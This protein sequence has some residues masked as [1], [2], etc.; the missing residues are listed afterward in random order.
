MAD[1][2]LRA[3]LSRPPGPRPRSGYSFW[4]R[5]WASLTG[6]TLPRR[7]MQEASAPLQA[8][9]RHAREHKVISTPSSTVKPVFRRSSSVSWRIAF[10][11]GAVGAG[12]AV[13]VGGVTA[14]N[15]SGGGGNAAPGITASYSASAITSEPAT[16][17][18]PA[19]SAP[20]TGLPVATGIV[21]APLQDYVEIHAK[22]SLSSSVVGE[23]FDGDFVQIYCQA[24]GDVVTNPL[25]GQ[26]SRLWVRI[27]VGYVPDNVGYIS[28]SF[29]LIEENLTRIGPC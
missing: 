6:M 27:N 29:V 14:L 22:P 15:T 8:E 23:T 25:T 4:Q 24:R 3:L 10:V 20:A 21:Q 5:Y 9:T 2:Y 1:R 28:E 12:I 26:T 7:S 13:V 11:T 18:L 17:P 19:S 16:S